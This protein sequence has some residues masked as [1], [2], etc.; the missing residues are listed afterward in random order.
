MV[1]PYDITVKKACFNPL[2]RN[3]YYLSKKRLDVSFKHAVDL[4]RVKITPK[5]CLFFI[6]M[7]DSSAG[8]L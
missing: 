4:I 8:T 6:P 5:R 1:Y 3:R 2:K 7:Q